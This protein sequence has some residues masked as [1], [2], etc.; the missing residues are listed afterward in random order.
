MYP[1]YASRMASWKRLLLVC[2]GALLFAFNM[3]SFVHSGGLLPGG[4]AGA[5]T[6]LQQ[7][8]SSFFSLS[9]PYTPI[10]LLLNAFPIFIGF[11]FIGKKFTLFSLLMIVLSSFLTDMIPVQPITYDPLLVS[12]FGGLLNGL[13]IGLCLWGNA[14]SG[15]L[16]FI[17]IFLSQEKN[18][19]AWNYTFALNAVMLLIAGL[20][21]GLDQALYSIIFQFTST[22][23]VHVLYQKH[24]QHTLFIITN[25]PKEVF[26]TISAMTHHGATVFDGTG[27]YLEEPRSMVYSVVDSDEVKPVI[28][29]VR[30]ADSTAFVNVVRTD[31]MTGRF[32][33]RKED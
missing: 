25:H 5:S 21:F 22:Q 6:L 33:Q 30:Q 14:S 27:A 24:R 17:A 1:L 13:S 29:A 7:I 20:L 2:T 26:S 12:V 11:R 16:D 10:N 3:K 28:K 31:Q 18:M 23:V 9:I 19:D 4:I 32:F 15:G 8:F